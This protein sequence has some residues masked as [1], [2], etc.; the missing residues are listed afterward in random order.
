M[1]RS[2]SNLQHPY[3]QLPVQLPLC[4]PRP[5]GLEHRQR[6]STGYGIGLMPDARRVV[7]TQTRGSEVPESVVRQMNNLGG[8]PSSLAEPAYRKL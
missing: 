3:S 7:P 8:P 4:K 6:T 2:T 1:P 5:N